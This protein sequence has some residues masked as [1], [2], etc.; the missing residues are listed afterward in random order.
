MSAKRRRQQSGQ[1]I[2]LIGLLLVVLT[3]ILALAIDSG[4]SYVE[5][6][7]LQEAVDSG[8]L[9]AAD[10]YL[11]STDYLGAEQLAVTYYQRNE[12]VSGGYSCSPGLTAPPAGG[13]STFTCAFTSDAS[14]SLSMTV[15]D[16]TYRGSR[17][18]L[19]GHHSIPV[20]LI[21]I[22]NFTNQLPIAATATARA[23]IPRTNPALL[24]L[25]SGACGTGP[26]SASL[27]GSGTQIAITGDVVSDGTLVIPTGHT[28]PVSGNAT[29]TCTATLPATLENVCIAY[30]VHDTITTSPCTSPKIPPVELNG[31]AA[32]A[33]PG[34]R[35][36]LEPAA[37]S[38]GFLQDLVN[39]VNQDV[40]VSVSI[41]GGVSTNPCYFLPGGV[42]KFEAG[43][44]MTAGLI[45]NELKPPDEPAV[46]S[47]LLTRASKQFWDGNG[48]KCAGTF[49]VSAVLAAPGT[50]LPAGNYGVVLTSVRTDTVNGVTY[51]RESAPSMCRT[52]TTN[53]PSSLLNVA[54]SNV[55]GAANYGLYISPPKIGQTGGC[56]GNYQFIAN[57][58]NSST[59]ANTNTSGCP[60]TTT[61]PLCSLGV[62]TFSVNLATL[63]LGLL[64]FAPPP[65]QETTAI[66]PS[67]PN[68]TPAA[69]LLPAGDRANENGCAN[70]TGAYLSIGTCPVPAPGQSATVVT[71]G[72]VE[73]W[74]PSGGCVTIAGP[75]G[76]SPGAQVFLFSGY[77]YQNN[78][79]FEPGSSQTGQTANTCANSIAGALNTNSQWH[80]NV[81]VPAASITLS[82]VDPY[83]GLVY[84][85]VTANTAAVSG[86]NGWAIQYNP[87]GD[88]PPQPAHL[89]Q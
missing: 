88:S 18:L 54:I 69:G 6:R 35:V 43:F 67:L 39:Q 37:P 68:Q 71:P 66:D 83:L 78:V 2:V 73:F 17:F 28:V 1:A 9:A 77:Q 53:A 65:S 33:D 85:T 22:V 4:R 29:S 82:G 44:S 59:E 45:S 14:H 13:S 30:V 8:A 12:H 16:D 62:S 49:N 74:V 21:Q 52:I 19:T 40:K 41:P 72:A 11:H 61:S 87:Y 60:S 10:H 86:V 42:Y 57:I 27:D 46:G 76:A 34:G 32:T 23:S 81:Y 24:T 55:P 64:S 38:G 79:L 48:V 58:P 15:T 63:T 70:L 7:Q 3:G 5:R 36:S 56:D 26:D 20:A 89:I 75:A 51:T 50:G 80:G 25:G 31:V 47:N 84:G